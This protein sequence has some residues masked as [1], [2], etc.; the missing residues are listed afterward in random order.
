[1]RQM[2]RQRYFVTTLTPQQYGF[3][4]NI[5]QLGMLILT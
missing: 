5:S 3:Y 2:E 1:M 4:T